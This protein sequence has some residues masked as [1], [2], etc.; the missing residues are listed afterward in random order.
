MLVQEVQWQHV[1]SNHRMASNGWSM[2]A[3]THLW[4]T[5]RVLKNRDNTQARSSRTQAFGCDTE[6]LLLTR[7]LFCTRRASQVKTQKKAGWKFQSKSSRPSYANYSLI[8]SKMKAKTRTSCGCDHWNPMGL[9]P[10]LFKLSCA[11]WHFAR[12]CVATSWMVQ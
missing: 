10:M 3:P 7:C 6:N 1:S 11:V 5:I 9:S 8:E 4:Q 2:Q 12:I